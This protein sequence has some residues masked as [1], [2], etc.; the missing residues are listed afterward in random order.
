MPKQI[1]RGQTQFE[2]LRATTRSCK[3]ERCRCQG[4]S[5]KIS[6][7]LSSVQTADES[8]GVSF[9]DEPNSILTDTNSAISAGAAYFFRFGIS[10]GLR[11][12]STSS[13]ISWTRYRRLVFLRPRRSL[14]KLLL[15]SVFTGAFARGERSD[16]GQ[17]FWSQHP[18]GSHE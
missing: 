16:R 5:R 3:D 7:D 13:M 11:A 6:I 4:R 17:Q 14:A 15:N 2:S 12:C 10:S 1:L 18:P 8:H 9:D